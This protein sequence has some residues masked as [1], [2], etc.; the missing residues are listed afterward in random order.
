VS[1]NSI[2]STQV[3]QGGVVLQDWADEG[4]NCLSSLMAM[5]VCPGDESTRLRGYHR[6]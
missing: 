6:Q 5:V 3:A 1:V 2:T 4:D